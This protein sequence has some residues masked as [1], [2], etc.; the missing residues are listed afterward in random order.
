MSIYDA[1][2]KYRPSYTS[3]AEGTDERRNEKLS[4]GYHST[5]IY[6]IMRGFDY[7]HPVAAADKAPGVVV[8]SDPK[9][10]IARYV[11][12]VAKEWEPS[13]G[14]AIMRGLYVRFKMDPRLSAASVSALADAIR[15]H[16]PSKA[17]VILK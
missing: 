10:E 6:A 17:A 5:E 15:T 4:F 8:L 3:P 13:V 11:G 9:D 1:A 14:A 7:K 2:T 16:F 12:L